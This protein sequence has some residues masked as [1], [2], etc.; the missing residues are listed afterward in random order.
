MVANAQIFKGNSFVIFG[1]TGTGC[2]L[3]ELKNSLSQL[4]FPQPLE[5]EYRSCESHVMGT[6]D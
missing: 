4:K 2:T 1:E 6:Q 3:N 5:L